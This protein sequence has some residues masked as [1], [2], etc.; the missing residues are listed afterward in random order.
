MTLHLSSAS[1]AVLPSDAPYEFGGDPG[2]FSDSFVD[3]VF[4]FGAAERFEFYRGLLAFGV[5][6]NNWTEFY[7]RL[8]RS[9][10]QSQ[11]PFLTRR[12]PTAIALY[13]Q[14][15]FRFLKAGAEGNQATTVL[16]AFNDPHIP[17]YSVTATE[18]AKLN[19]Y[20]DPF[21][22][23]LQQQENPI[24]PTHTWF[25]S[26]FPRVQMYM[27]QVFLDPAWDSDSLSFNVRK[28]RLMQRLAELS[29]LRSRLEQLKQF[30]DEPTLKVL[31]TSH[32]MPIVPNPQVCDIS[33]F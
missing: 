31:Q 5:E 1:F 28:T 25:A 17:A 10:A 30:V 7:R 19:S 16:E 15:M 4:G 12:G 8:S 18:A 24:S 3:I 29:L 21:M 9:A 33:S 27:M 6:F 11:F 26:T 14:Q 22:R 2:P 23:L 20:S 32:E 13:G